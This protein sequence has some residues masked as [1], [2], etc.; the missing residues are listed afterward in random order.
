[1]R[2]CVKW[3]I[4]GLFIRKFTWNLRGTK[5]RLQLHNNREAVIVW[6]L[7]LLRSNSKRS[8]LVEDKLYFYVLDSVICISNN[9]LIR[10]L[11]EGS[12]GI[13]KCSNPSLSRS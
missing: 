3:A 10:Y 12:R 1:M 2:L 8:A 11:F 13:L 9:L 4:L 5:C 6:C 7:L